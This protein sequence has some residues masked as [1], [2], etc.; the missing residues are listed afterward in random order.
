MRKNTEVMATMTNTMAVV[1]AVSRRVG[2]VT[3]WASARTSCKNLNGL[4][5]AMIPAAAFSGVGRGPLYITFPDHWS[6]PQAWQEWRDSNPQPPVLETGAL[7]IELHSSGSDCGG[8]QDQTLGSAANCKCMI[9]ARNASPQEPKR[10]Q[11]EPAA[12]PDLAAAHHLARARNDVRR[13]GKSP[14]ER[15]RHF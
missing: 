4:I 5:F 10:E 2:H 14:A 15:A 12:S 1:M 9:D 8:S 11:N 6:P 3:F 7:A 13:Q